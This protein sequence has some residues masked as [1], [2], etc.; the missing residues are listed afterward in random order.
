MNIE[1]ILEENTLYSFYGVWGN[2]F[3]LGSI[4][5]NAIEDPDDG[6]RSYLDSVPM[7]KSDSTFYTKPIVNVYFTKVGEDFIYLKDEKQHT[8]LSVG[9]DHSDDYYPSFVFDYTP[10][11]DLIDFSEELHNL[12]SFD[13]KALHIEKLI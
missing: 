7:V 3:K 9:T 11:T 1:D 5:F 4:V 8:W 2:E 13:P 10:R 12:D 6:Y